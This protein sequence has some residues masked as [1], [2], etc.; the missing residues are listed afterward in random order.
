MRVIRM[1]LVL[2]ALNAVLPD[3]LVAQPEQPPMR[4]VPEKPPFNRDVNIV[5]ARGRITSETPRALE[6]YL[7]DTPGSEYIYWIAFDSEGG[8]LAAALELGRLLRRENLRTTVKNEHCKDAFLCDDADEMV[9]KARCSSA[10]AYAFLGGIER[11]LDVAIVPK[12]ATLAP[13]NVVDADDMEDEKANALLGF[14]Q[15]SGETPVVASDS[16][17]VAQLVAQTTSAQSQLTSSDLARYIDEM[18]VGVEVMGAASNIAPDAMG[19]PTM[20]DLRRMRVLFRERF[21][22][23]RLEPDGTGVSAIGLFSSGGAYSQQIG[24]HCTERDRK[25]GAPRFVFS[26]VQVGRGRRWIKNGNPAVPVSLAEIDALTVKPGNQMRAEPSP[27][28]GRL[29][30]ENYEA[31]A[32]Q[33]GPLDIVNDATIVSGTEVQGIPGKQVEMRADANWSHIVVRPS[34]QVM[35]ALLD[36]G[37]FD[38]SFDAPNYTNL[39]SFPAL[40]FD[41]AERRRIGVAVR[42]CL[43][44]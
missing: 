23:I 1:T 35:R 3:R 9:P 39:G 22:P 4:F 14:H 26:R 12:L 33:A 38:L 31:Y 16:P 32:A 30:R 43:G 44:E 2:V 34:P 42:Q 11:R 20:N 25:L 6:K 7:K 19:H 37:A 8:N 18:G 24:F 40:R 29:L 13:Y 27:K 36:T 10:C 21:L 41:E 28:T 17:A 15:F 5:Y